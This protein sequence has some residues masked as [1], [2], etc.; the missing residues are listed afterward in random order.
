MAKV[1]KVK[2]VKDIKY[3]RRIVDSMYTQ[4]FT[5][6]KLTT[7]SGITATIQRQHG[8]DIT[9]EMVYKSLLLKP[10]HFISFRPD[11]PGC[12]FLKKNE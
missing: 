4:D 11:C 12:K 1:K 5:Y 7:I 2:N 3:V 9:Y 6:T 10:S 8:S